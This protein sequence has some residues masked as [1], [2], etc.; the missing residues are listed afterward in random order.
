MTIGMKESEASRM[1]SMALKVAGLDNGGCL[2]LFGGA[3]IAFPS[4]EAL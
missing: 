1:M 3:R 2:T 4:R